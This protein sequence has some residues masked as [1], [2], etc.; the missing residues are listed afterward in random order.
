MANYRKRAEKAVGHTFKPTTSL[1]GNICVYCGWDGFT[2]DHVPGIV[3]VYCY[4]L[5]QYPRI[6]VRA[7]RECNSTLSSLELRG[8]FKNC[9]STQAAQRLV[10]IQRLKTLEIV[11]VLG[12]EYWKNKI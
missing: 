12:L 3:N 5:E 6:I 9:V 11:S 10:I 8:K 4:K 7:C 1:D 2:R